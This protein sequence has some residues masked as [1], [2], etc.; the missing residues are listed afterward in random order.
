[1]QS[2]KEIMVFFLAFPTRDHNAQK[3]A[4]T[5]RA[6]FAKQGLEFAVGQLDGIES[7]E[8]FGSRDRAEV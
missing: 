6:N 7:G 2:S 4:A 3:V 1:M 5:P 8:Y